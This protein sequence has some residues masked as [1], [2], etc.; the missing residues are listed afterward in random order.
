[1]KLI[2]I[3]LKHKKLRLVF[4][5][6]K[7]ELVRGNCACCGSSQIFEICKYEDEDFNSTRLTFAEYLDYVFINVNKCNECGYVNDDLSQLVGEHT[8]EIV[9]SNEYKEI[10]DNGFMGQYKELYGKY[11][12]SI[13]CGVYDAFAKLYESENKFEL[14]YFKILNTIYNLKSSLRAKYFED[15]CEFGNEKDSKKYDELISMLTFQINN[16]NEKSVSNLMEL[17]IDNKY[18][19]ILIAQIFSRSNRRDLAKNIVNIYSQKYQIDEQ[20]EEFFKEI[21]SEIEVV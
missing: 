18:A 15:M 8:R 2:Q 16:V 14:K 9:K 4:M 11:Y 3:K 6:R 5:F 13:N 21:T 7:M 12:E 1:M 10:L 17:Q 20:L 19:Q